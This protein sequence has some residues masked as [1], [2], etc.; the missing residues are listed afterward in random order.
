MLVQLRDDITDIGPALLKGKS[1]Q[2]LNGSL[3]IAYAREV[4]PE[5]ERERLSTCLQSLPAEP[6]AVQELVALLDRCRAGL[7]L[8]AEI[9][10]VGGE[11]NSALELAEPIRPAGEKLADMLSEL[12]NF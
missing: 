10:R 8:Q 1:P 9:V 3:A 12:S 5:A 7:Y 11:G 6:E 4:L 2:E